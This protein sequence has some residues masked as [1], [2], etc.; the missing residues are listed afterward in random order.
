MFTGIIEDVGVVQKI[1]PGR[2]G[3]KRIA[4]GTRFP[5]ETIEIG[6][7]ISTSGVCLTV[8]HKEGATFAIDA[9][10]ETLA[11]TTLGGLTAGTRVNLER[12]VTPATRLGGHLVQGHVDGVGRIVSVRKRENAFDF[13][14]E[15]PE[16]VLRLAAPR[17]S[18]AVD[19]ISLTITG[20]A[21]SSFSV[22]IIPHTHAV[23]TIGDRKPGDTVNLEADLIARYVA[24]LLEWTENPEKG[25]LT[26]AFLAEHGF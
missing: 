5:E 26:E 19:G 6:D 18:I 25:G 4:I 11:R 22:S 12:S 3:G 8:V 21:R 10:P 1:G 2:E 24:G 14:I 17:G 16:E 23:T 20:R 9:G 15:A 13:E 7:S